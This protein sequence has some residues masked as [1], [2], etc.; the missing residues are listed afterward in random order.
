MVASRFGIVPERIGSIINNWETMNLDSPED[1]KY[2]VNMATAVNQIKQTSTAKVINIGGI[3]AKAQL[4]LQEFYKDYTQR[5]DINNQLIAQGVDKERPIMNLDQFTKNWFQL[6]DSKDT[7]SVDKIVNAFA[8]RTTG[9]NGDNEEYQQILEELILK[10]IKKANDGIWNNVTEFFGYK[11]GVVTGKPR[12][13]S[14][15]SIDA[16]GWLYM[17]PD[18]NA[19]AYEENF[20]RDM[21]ADLLPDYIPWYYKAKGQNELDIG[22]KSKKEIIK[23]LEEMMGFLMQDIKSMGYMLTDE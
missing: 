1:I 17:T 7:D 22:Q 21:Y 9:V 23:D 18:E 19:L 11:R 3:D 6:R 8:I 10:E 15:I 16:L 5:A 13:E 20:A 14:H 12:M 2:L 4:Y